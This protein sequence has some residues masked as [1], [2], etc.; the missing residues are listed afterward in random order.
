MPD[1]VL[2]SGAGRGRSTDRG[3]LRGS[4]GGDIR[5]AAQTAPDA[6]VQRHHDKD[7]AAAARGGTQQTVLLATKL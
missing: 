2:L 3:R 7:A 6:A 4:A 1:I 5:R